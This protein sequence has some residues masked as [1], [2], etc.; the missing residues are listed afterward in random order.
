MTITIIFTPLGAILA[1]FVFG[2]SFLLKNRYGNGINRFPGP[3]AASLTYF[4]RLRD[5]YVNGDK[6]P[7]FV[8][9]HEKYGEIIRLGPKTLSF[10]SPLALDDIYGPGSNMEKVSH[11]SRI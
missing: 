8:A 7:S 11:L 4:W 6:R 2:V 1:A 3:F 9:L 10:S 5:A